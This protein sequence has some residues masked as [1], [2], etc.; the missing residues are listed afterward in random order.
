MDAAE[1]LPTA[2]V[3]FRGGGDAAQIVYANRASAELVGA[4]GVDELRGKSAAW[5]DRSFGG[6]GGAQL[7]AGAGAG[8]CVHRRLSFKRLRDQQ[9]TE[10]M[11]AWVPVLD[12]TSRPAF[13][14]AM[15]IES[16]SE[17]GGS[18]AQGQLL[19]LASVL[20][21]MPRCC[22]VGTTLAA[23]PSMY[24]MA[25]SVE[26]FN[27]VQRALVDTRFPPFPTLEESAAGGD[28]EGDG[29]QDAAGVGVS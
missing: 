2:A 15:L 18:A 4:Q 23:D 3:V 21:L 8:A 11:Y 27:R 10:A 22:S 13:G 1:A 6:S 7:C 20:L 17:V 26:A 25:R 28:G 9:P 12:E 24:A 14:V 16:P 29:P 19:K 5:F